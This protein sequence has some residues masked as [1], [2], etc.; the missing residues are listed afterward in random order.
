MPR[1]QSTAIL[2]SLFLHTG[3]IDGS[4]AKMETTPVVTGLTANIQANLHEGGESANVVA[5]VF[6]NGSRINLIA[7]DVL[8]ASTENERVLL[9]SIEV[10]TGDYVGTLPLEHES[11]L[12]ALRVQHK[13]V[14]AREGRWYPVDI[15]TVD[16]GPGE[17]VG[18]SASVSIPGKLDLLG[19]YENTVYTSRSDNIDIIWTPL[20]EGDFMRL[21]AAVS[22]SN[23]QASLVYGLTYDAG[24]D[25]GHYSINMSDLA[26]N[27]TLTALALAFTDH[28][29]RLLF[30]AVTNVL[31]FGLINAEEFGKTPIQI[32]TATCDISLML[33]REREGTLGEEFDGGQ[34]IGST[35]ATTTILYRPEG[36]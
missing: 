16:P 26:Y 1:L 18:L 29:S 19:P 7:G 6:E 36:S 27:D 5:A 24:E 31:Y 25:D 13:P 17:H 9:E 10:H 21:T 22:C 32:E 23:G 14:E 8:E 28:I 3:C 12:I 20:G 34:A 15:L 4:Q 30:A 2:V 33:I 35:S 11:E